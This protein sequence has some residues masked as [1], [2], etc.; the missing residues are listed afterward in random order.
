MFFVS[1][2]KYFCENM[3]GPHSN[4]EVALIDYVLVISTVFIFMCYAIRGMLFD[5]GIVVL[6]LQYQ[7]CIWFYGGVLDYCFKRQLWVQWLKL[8]YSCMC[9]YEQL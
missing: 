1:K 6:M 5:L 8:L 4:L 3:K 2:K 9:R 7:Y